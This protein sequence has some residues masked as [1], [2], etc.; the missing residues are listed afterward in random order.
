MHID[1][2]R[3]DDEIASVEVAFAGSGRNLADGRDSI[4]GDGDVGGEPRVA[5]PVDDAAAAQDEVVPGFWL[6]AESECR[7]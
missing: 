2:A 5:G 4:G 3:R 1:E 6:G 7:N